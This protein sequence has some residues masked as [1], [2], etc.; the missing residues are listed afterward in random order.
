MMNP[1]NSDFP[2][3]F[4]GMGQVHI[5]A[6]P[7]VITTVLGSCISITMFNRRSEIGG[8][9][10]GLMPCC[11]DTKACDEDPLECFKFV[12]CSIWH[13]VEQFQM[14]GIAPKDIEVKM[15]GGASIFGTI[16]DASNLSVGDQNVKSAKQVITE[17][18]LNLVS[19]D[20]GG[21]SGRKILFYTHNG[22]VLLKEMKSTTT[23]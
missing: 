1:N 4:L 15:F 9:C 14:R 11:T 7:T 20:V 3:V 19:F 12:D 13:M 17:A 8:M 6:K 21:T 5:S 2:Q 16:P 10:H 23:Q 18:G 22:R